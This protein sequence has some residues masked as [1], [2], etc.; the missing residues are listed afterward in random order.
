[1]DL[2]LITIFTGDWEEKKP[3]YY[4][5]SQGSDTDVVDEDPEGIEKRKI[6]R[7]P[8]KNPDKNQEKEPHLKFLLYF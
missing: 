3:G 1:M 4:P 7:D 6:R 8:Y 5:F 2:K